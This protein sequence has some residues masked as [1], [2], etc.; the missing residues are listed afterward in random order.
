MEVYVN[1]EE[2]VSDATVALGATPQ[3]LCE[4]VVTCQ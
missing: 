3:G 4:V 2:L 1:Q